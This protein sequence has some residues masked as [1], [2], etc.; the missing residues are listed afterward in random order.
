MFAR[1][2][3]GSIA[4][5]CLVLPTIGNEPV[6]ASAKS[7][8]KKGTIRFQP[9]GDQKNVPERYRLEAHS[10]E[11]DMKLIRDLP[12]SGVEVYHV[13]FPSP[14]T[15]ACPENNT[16][17]AEYYRPVRPDRSSSASPEHER[18]EPP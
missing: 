6:D 16:V 15:T 3:V 2:M 10:F 5:S 12:N 8:V 9:V 7:R 1:L 4:F 11:Y 17:H 14:V 13:R 18:P